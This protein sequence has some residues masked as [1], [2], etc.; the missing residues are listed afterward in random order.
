MYILREF[1][2]FFWDTGW[3]FR[4][5][6]R[7]QP[8]YPSFIKYERMIVGY[9]QKISEAKNIRLHAFFEVK[10]WCQLYDPDKVILEKK[11]ILEKRSF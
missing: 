11:I 6:M 3:N 2:A 4:V 8:T 5:R 7:N 10:I 9:Y 1:G